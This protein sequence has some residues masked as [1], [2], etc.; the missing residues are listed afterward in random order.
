MFAAPSVA[1]LVPATAAHAAP[2]VEI[3]A[4]VCRQ[5]LDPQDRHYMAPGV[6][7]NGPLVFVDGNPVSTNG[8]AFQGWVGCYK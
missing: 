5:L 6:A 7:G 4:G 8:Q 2:A 1:I 3:N